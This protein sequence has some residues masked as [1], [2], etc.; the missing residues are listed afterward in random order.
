MTLVVLTVIV[1]ALLVA[2][3]AVFLFAIG[4]L[5]NRTADNL[6]DCARNVK[7][8]AH[9]AEVVGPALGRIKETG[10]TVVGALPLLCE[11]AERIGVAKSAPYVDPSETPY[12]APSRDNSSARSAVTSE[13]PHAAHAAVPV[14][15]TQSVGYLDEKR[16]SLGY[17]DA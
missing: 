11:A 16:G 7:T 9:Q 3:L 1:V 17:L 6:D 8:V 5:L 10:T 15:E 12:S 13:A 2:V 4:V 14:A